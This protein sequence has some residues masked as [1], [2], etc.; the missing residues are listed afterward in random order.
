MN[1]FPTKKVVTFDE[2]QTGD[3]DFGVK[4]QLSKKEMEHLTEDEI[5]Y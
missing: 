1:P 2:K 3:G 5:R 4:L